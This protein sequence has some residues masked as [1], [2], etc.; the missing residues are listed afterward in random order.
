LVAHR[1]LLAVVLGLFLGMACARGQSPASDSASSVPP[2]AGASRDVIGAS[3]S[4]RA[5]DAPLSPPISVRAGL[6][7]AA[8]NAGIYVAQEKGYFREQGLD[9]D[10]AEFESATPLVPLLASGQVEIGGSGTTAGLMN[11]VARDIPIRIVADRGTTYPGF[12][13]QGVVV[14]Q[15]LVTS[16]AFQGCASFKGLRVANPAEGNSLQVA[17][18]RLLQSCGLGLA[19]VEQVWMGF[20]DMP[21]AFRNGAIDAAFMTEPNLTRGAAEGLFTLYQRTDEFYP[22]QQIAVLMYSPQF[23]ATQREAGQRFMVAYLRGV[24]DYWEAFAN[25][26]N[27]AEIVDVLTRWTT[28]KDPALYERMAPAGLNPDGYVNLR[29][30]A[31]DVQWWFDQGYMKTRVEPTQ[32]IDHSFVDYAIERLGRY[33]AR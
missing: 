26:A 24:R 19:D 15:D 18:A 1:G 22:D 11:A 27:K 31:S 25:G 16:G 2:V 10:I 9:V 8:P 14:R 17:L 21:A 13:F 33:S 29:T 6:V 3:A 4:P 30:F 7:G 23:M 28:L 5:T 12:G 32:V 20:G